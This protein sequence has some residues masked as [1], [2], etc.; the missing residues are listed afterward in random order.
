MN[1][2]IRKRILQYERIKNCITSIIVLISICLACIIFRKTVAPYQFWIQCGLLILILYRIFTCTY[3][4]ILELKFWKYELD[5]E[6][7]ATTNGWFFVKHTIIPM[8]RVQNVEKKTNPLLQKYQLVCVEIH[9]TT[10]T[11]TLRRI[12]VQEAEQMTA[13]IMKILKDKYQVREDKTHASI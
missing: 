1:Q 12:E 2:E 9:T 6:K 13:Q 5:E 11:H 8:A 3:K 10:D 4:P 7:I